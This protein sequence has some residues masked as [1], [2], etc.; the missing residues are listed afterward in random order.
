MRCCVRADGRGLRVFGNTAT[1]FGGAYA[2]GLSMLL[3][4]I[5]DLTG[6]S[7]AARAPRWRFVCQH[8]RFSIV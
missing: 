5:C 2:V 6:P 1:A 7:L 3:I 4:F 8:H